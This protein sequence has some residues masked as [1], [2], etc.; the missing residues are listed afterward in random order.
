MAETWLPVPGWPGYAVSDLG[1]VRSLDRELRDGRQ[2]GGMILRQTPNGEGYLMVTLS[3]GFRRKRVAV[4]LLVK[5][6]FTGPP[7]GRQVRHRDDDKANCKLSNLV[8]GWQRDNERDKQKNRERGR[9]GKGKKRE[10]DETGRGVPGYFSLFPAD[11]R[12]GGG[13]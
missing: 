11:S 7:R 5:R 1:R 13:R 2:A 12:P 10:T 3:D 8:Y 6:T 9:K 4:H